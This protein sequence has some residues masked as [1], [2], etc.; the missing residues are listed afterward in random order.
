MEGPV[1][2]GSS[3]GSKSAKVCECPLQWRKQYHTHLLRRLMEQ[4][5][6]KARDDARHEYND[7]VRASVL[8]CGSI[9]TRLLMSIQGLVYFVRKR[10]PRY[11]S[12]L[13]K[14]SQLSS[15]KSSTLS[16]AAQLR[17]DHAASVYIEQEWQKIG[18]NSGTQTVSD[19]FG[20]DEA[21]FE[22]SG[23]AEAWECVACGKTFRS[24]KA[25]S[26]HERDR[27]S[28][29]LN[30]SHRIASRMPSSA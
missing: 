25:W 29:R 12:H 21:E 22:V 6:K 1:E 9:P 11:K 16:S 27:K 13:A 8:S 24:E 30:S 19:E 7:A 3:T 17:R 14:Q 10:D 5:N 18:S 26:N 20:G 23:D 15:T 2:F 28:T 4:D